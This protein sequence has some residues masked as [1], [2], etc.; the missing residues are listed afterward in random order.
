M[1]SPV[2]VTRAETIAKA[3][4]AVQDV[5]RSRAATQHAIERSRKSLVET[6]ALLLALRADLFGIHSSCPPTH[7]IAKAVTRRSSALKPSPSM[8]R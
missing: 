5:R 7:I 2:T 4:Q 8:K 1:P 6:H 3:C